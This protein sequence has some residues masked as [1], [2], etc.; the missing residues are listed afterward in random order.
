[1]YTH[2]VMLT[3]GGAALAA[4]VV[5]SCRSLIR[6]MWPAARAGT[7][8]SR[9]I[10]WIGGDAPAAADAALVRGAIVDERLGTYDAVVQS[11]AD[12]LFSADQAT[13]GSAVDAGLLRPWHELEARRMLAGLSGTL[14]EI[15]E[16]GRPWR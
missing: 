3:L 14:V 9:Q 8:A 16:E 10:R 4:S 12:R 5:S 2:Q 7:P 11:V 6:L 1:M 13:G 15:E